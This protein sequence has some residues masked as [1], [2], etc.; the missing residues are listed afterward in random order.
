MFFNVY[1]MMLLTYSCD[2]VTYML[3]V[4]LLRGPELNIGRLL[5]NLKVF[6]L[7]C[8]FVIKL[9][10]IFSPGMPVTANFFTEHWKLYYTTWLIRVMVVSWE[11][12][13]ASI[14]LGRALEQTPRFHFFPLYAS[15]KSLHLT[16]GD[17][18]E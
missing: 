2:D 14:P 12:R 16:V 8:E 5:L 11:D 1:V 6:S 13:F 7:L 17:N 3:Y 15:Q 18:S 10:T 9:W 4:S